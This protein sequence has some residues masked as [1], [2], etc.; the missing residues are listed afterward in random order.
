MVNAFQEGQRFAQERTARRQ[1]IRGINALGKEFGTG[2]LAPAA[3]A[4]VT[5]SERAERKLG[6]DQE[7]RA[8]TNQRNVGAD[9]RLDA[10][11]AR[12]QEEFEIAEQTRVMGA[13]VGFYQTGRD[14]GVS[15][16]EITKRVSPA[17]LKLGIDEQELGELPALLA[18]DPGILDRLKGALDEQDVAGRRLIGTPTVITDANGDQSEIQH[19]TDG[20]QR[21]VALPPGSRTQQSIAAAN[22][23]NTSARKAAVAEEKIEPTA[24]ELLSLVKERGKTVGKGEGAV[25]VEDL[26]TSR[27]AIAAQKAKIDSGVA[28]SNR[29]IAAIKSARD[30]VS[31]ISAG[32]IGGVTSFIPGTPAF[33]LVE[34]IL[35]AISQEFV[36][37]LQNMRDM[38]KTGGAV[39]NVSNAEG[40]K[41]QALRGSLNIGQSPP[42][43]LKNM[44]LMEDQ[45]IASRALI[46]RAWDDDQAARAEAA[47][48]GEGVVRVYN[49]ETGKFEDAQ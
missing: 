49:I 8:I 36:A 27:T 2:A 31:A 12:E 47:G 30:Q 7:Q 24:A 40:D 26:P 15:F 22:R 43:L 5:G 25:I 1:Q 29:A 4:A 20:T 17:L 44:Q 37:N 46:Q 14:N 39:G 34:E 18:A 33:N 6:F 9:R 28:T 23:A 32:F 21:I 38:S 11:A 3:F 10:T 13:I 45:I 42:Q 35:P 48:G 19:F 41:L 16:E